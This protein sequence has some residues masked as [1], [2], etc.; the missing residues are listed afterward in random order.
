MATHSTVH[1][2]DSVAAIDGTGIAPRVAWVIMKHSIFLLFTFFSMF[3][4]QSLRVTSAGGAG[5]VSVVLPNSAPWTTI[6]GSPGVSTSQPMRWEFRVHDVY[7]SWNQY[8]YS[9][10]VGVINQAASSIGF[11]PQDST[12]DFVSRGQGVA[13]VG[14][15]ITIRIQRDVANSR[16]TLEACSVATGSCAFDP[17]FSAIT[18]LSDP[19]FVNQ[20]WYIKPGRSV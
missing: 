13:T 17:C 15:D 7:S 19:S 3:A 6:A 18:K 14:T 12:W 16:Y 4:G 11:G 9:V 5:Y 2:G 1:S 10:G 8:A 20:L